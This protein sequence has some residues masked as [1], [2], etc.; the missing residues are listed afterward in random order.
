MLLRS[1]ETN[2]S[3]RPSTAATDTSRASGSGRLE[4]I[5][6]LRAY[7]ALWVVLGHVLWAAGFK[8][9]EL[10]GVAG[11]I[12][13]PEL[14]VDV[15]IIVS[16]F[17]IFLALD[18]KRDGYVPFIV[19]RFFRMFPLFILL[20]FVAIPV[21]TITMWNATHAAQ[22]LAPADMKFDQM[23]AWWDDLRWHVP[24]HLTMLHGVVPE[25]ILP[26]A[27]G[28]FLIPAWSVSLEWQFYLIA[29]LAFAFATSPRWLF[30]GA[31]VA[32]CGAMMFVDHG[33]ID[34]VA[35]GAAL[36][37]HVEYF[38]VGGASYFLYAR[39]T[40]IARPGIWFGLGCVGAGSLYLMRGVITWSPVPWMLWLVFLGLILEQPSSRARRLLSPSFTNPVSQYLG[41]IS[42]SIYLSHMLV[43]SFVQFALL[44]AVPQLG[45]S[46]HLASLLVATLGVTVPISIALHRHVE[47]PGIAFGR[48]L[49]GRLDRGRVVKWRAARARDTAF[50]LDRTPDSPM[51][52]RGARE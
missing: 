37:F 24:L 42:Y 15:F 32:V 11:L 38:A 35:Y 48:R 46:G 26:G 47:I 30:R 21:S 45:R 2:A 27:P 51:S 34:S 17:V 9:E 14:A 50:R 7:L 33:D 3:D 36:P 8:R 41:R 20:F 52:A 12:R 44:N 39:R 43:I 13:T 6:G 1:L 31:L 25:K 29:P 49:A 19:R 16:G 40:M 22:Y 5:E 4:A 28:A 18:S 10:S 23:V